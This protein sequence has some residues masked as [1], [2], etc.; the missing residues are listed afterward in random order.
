MREVVFIKQNK[1]RWQDYEQ[2]TSDPDELAQRFANLVDDI[3]YARTHYPFSETVV[4]LNNLASNIY[5]SIYK[6]KKKEPNWFKQ[7]FLEDVP[8]TVYRHRKVLLFASVFFVLLYLIGLF[9]SQ[10][11]PDFIRAVLSDEYVN[12][13][14]DNIQQGKPF[15]VYDERNPFSMFVQI[16]WNNIRVALITFSSFAYIL[17]DVIDALLSALWGEGSNSWVIWCTL[18]VPVIYWGVRIYTKYRLRKD[19][20]SLYPL[21]HTEVESDTK[22]ERGEHGVALAEKYTND[23][24]FIEVWRNI[25]VTYFSLLVGLLC[26]AGAMLVLFRNGVMVGSFHQMFIA[27]G[28]GIKWIFVVMIHG[29]LELFSIAVAGGC[30]MMLGNALLFPGTYKRMAALKKAAVDAVRIMSVVI[31]MLLIAAVFESY[32]TRYE[33]MPVVMSSLILL[34]CTA[35]IVAYFYLLPRNVQRRQQSEHRRI[36]NEFLRIPS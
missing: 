23:I 31:L 22:P 26:M 13:T 27:H 7:Y 21:L 25:K 32:V 24:L 6:A 3:G 1:Q 30:G 5:L 17:F 11:N 14:R 35:F 34:V 2:Y 8:L 19:P 28:F 10:K 36:R 33:D 18:A 12:M 9:V 20:A 15:G 4:Y 16:A 29:T